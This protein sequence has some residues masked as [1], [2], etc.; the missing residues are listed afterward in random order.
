V[1]FVA[2]LRGV[3][4]GGRNT[5]R[6]TELARG[7]APWEV[8]SVGAAGTLVVRGAPSPA[9]VRRAILARLPFEPAI[10]IRPAGEVLALVARAPFRGTRAPGD[11]RAWVTVLDGRP[12]ARPR[13]P[14][15]APAGA[16]WS[17]RFLRLEG[18]F[19]IGFWR[20]RP[21]G[22]VFPSHVVERATGVA[23]TTR[24]WETIERV[25]ALL[26]R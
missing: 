11:S 16:A 18:A 9:A 12:R 10:A 24:W 14:L 7:L 3:N 17:V 8:A 20:R 4:V 19:A 15:S 23:A 13:L 21:G 22:F 5:L 25:A 6:P 26:R 2:F 1:E